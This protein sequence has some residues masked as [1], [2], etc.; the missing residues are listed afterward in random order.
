M[1]MVLTIAMMMAEIEYAAGDHDRHDVD[2][3]FV[4]VFILSEPTCIQVEELRGRRQ[5]DR[6]LENVP[7]K[8]VPRS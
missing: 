8:R 2:D 1:T 3:F 7:G 4:R 5:I 6:N